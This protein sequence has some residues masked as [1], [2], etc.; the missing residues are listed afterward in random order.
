MVKFAVKM[1][2]VADLLAELVDQVALYTGVV[3]ANGVMGHTCCLL[4]L[5]TFLIIIDL[6]IF[7]R[8]SLGRHDVGGC[9]LARLLFFISQID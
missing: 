2:G 9:S 5:K 6:N 4:L 7:Y 1:T 8:V 3:D